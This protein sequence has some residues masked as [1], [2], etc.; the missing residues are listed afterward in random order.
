VIHRIRDGKIVEYWSV[1]DV[2]HVLQQIG[3]LP[4]PPA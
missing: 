3:A 4:G 2:A 1:V